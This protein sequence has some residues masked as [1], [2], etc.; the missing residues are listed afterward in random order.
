LG[1][2]P[3]VIGIIFLYLALYPSINVK[4]LFSRI[5]SAVF[6]VGWGTIYK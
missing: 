4:I 6:L 1:M 2:M 3:I 5:Y